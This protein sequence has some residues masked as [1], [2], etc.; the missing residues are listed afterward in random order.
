MPLSLTRTDSGD[1][2][3]LEALS[4]SSSLNRTNEALSPTRWQYQSQA[5]MVNFEKIFK[6]EIEINRIKIFRTETEIEIGFY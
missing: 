6:I 4:A 1:E 3:P 2:K 5:G